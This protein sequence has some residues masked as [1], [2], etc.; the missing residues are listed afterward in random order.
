MKDDLFQKCYGMTGNFAE[1]RANDDQYFINPILEGPAGPH[2]SFQG[3][4]MIVWALNNY[5]GLAD[6]PEIKQAA[7][8]A[9]EKWSTTTPMG[10]RLMTGNTPAH[11]VLEKKLA[12]FCQKSD[13]Y[14]SPAGYL[15]VVG[16]IT[17]LMGKGDTVIIDQ[18]SHACMVDGAF[19]AESKSGMRVKPFKHNDMKD[20]ER[21]LK[22]TY[23]ENKGGALVVT[24]GVFGM[25]GDLANL[26]EICKLKEQYG[27]RLF[28]DDAHGFGVIGP[29]GRGTGEYFGLQDKVDIYFGTFAKAFVSI[30]SI[31][32]GPEEVI[33]YLRLNSRPAIFSKALPL[34]LIHAIDKALD[35]IEQHPEYRDKMWR[36]THKLQKGLRGLGYNL[37]ATQAPITPVYVSNGDRDMAIKM[38]R[39]LRDEFQIFVTAVTYP[40]VP[41]GTILFRLV[42]T[43]AH[44]DEDVEVTLHAFQMMRDQLQL[45]L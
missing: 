3:K 39:L 35:L 44:S 7:L 37:G 42:P 38:I 19:L 41:R 28:L 31:T 23:D 33:S 12:N 45:K 8:A 34:V 40:V 21:Q 27:A 4:K 18:F 36:I 6:H 24:E 25:R 29:N 22:K 9:V 13:G 30:G 11:T 43:A 26:P 2:M 20:L 14:L 10:A 15:G 16:G 32:C 17:G 1:Q 5:L